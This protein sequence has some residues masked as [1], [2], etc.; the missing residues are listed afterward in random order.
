[1]GAGCSC[2]GV[3]LS[4]ETTFEQS[5]SP[6]PFHLCCWLGGAFSVE[7]ADTATVLEVKQQIAASRPNAATGKVHSSVVWLLE[8]TCSFLL[9]SSFSPF[10]PF[11]S[12]E[13]TPK[14]TQ[15]EP[16]FLTLSV[17]MGPLVVFAEN[18]KLIYAGKSNHPLLFKIFSSLFASFPIISFVQN[19]PFMHRAFSI[20]KFL[21]GVSNTLLYLTPL[22]CV[23]VCLCWV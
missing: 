20:A 23:F 5:N 10:L 7:V 18:Q 3:H 12:S 17:L 22:L 6:F 19:L 1:M 21:C 2:Y 14:L 13:Q 15:N 9:L 8:H 16:P 11:F 4:F